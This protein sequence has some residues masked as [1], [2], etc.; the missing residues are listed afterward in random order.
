MIRES[1]YVASSWRNPHHGAVVEALRG[2][3]LRPYDFKASSSAFRW[4]ELDPSGSQGRR[5]SQSFFRSALGDRSVKL[6]FFTDYEAMLSSRQCALI[7]PAGRSAH[8]EAG[9]FAG[10]GRPLAIYAPE[11]MEPELAYLLS[12]RGPSAICLTMDE[13]IQTL[14]GG[15]K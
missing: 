7:L 5:W 11:P 4:E 12:A 9:W 10:K 15:V 6:G 13:L 3:G 8:L 1:V 2:A 14:L